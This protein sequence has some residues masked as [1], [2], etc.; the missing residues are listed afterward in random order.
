M[1][2][3]DA[4]QAIALTLERLKSTFGSEVLEQTTVSAAK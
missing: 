3:A 2:R 1:E 4:P